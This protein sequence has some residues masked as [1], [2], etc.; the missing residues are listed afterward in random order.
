MAEQKKMNQEDF[1]K[2]LQTPRAPSSG[3]PALLGAGGA[4]PKQAPPK[5]PRDSGAFAKPDGP[6]KKKKPYK[7]P[8]DASAKPEGPKYRDRAA[9]RRTAKDEISTDQLLRQLNSAEGTELDSR[10]LYEQSKYLGGDTEHTHLVKGLDFALLSKVRSEMGRDDGDK[11]RGEEEAE[12]EL[13]VRLRDIE[14]GKK[15]SKA[16]EGNEERPD[17]GSAMAANVYEIVREMGKPIEKRWPKNNELFRT[18][19]MCFVFELADPV[20]GEVEDPFAIPTTVIRSKADV[21][22]WAAQEAGGGGEEGAMVIEKVLQVMGS[23]RRGE[24]GAVGEEG[25]K[26]KKGKEKEKEKTGEGDRKEKKELVVAMDEDEDIFADVGRDYKL[27]EVGE[28]ED[29][30]ADENIATSKDIVEPKQGK[31]DYFGGLPKHHSSDSDSDHAMDVDPHQTLDSILTQANVQPPTIADPTIDK[32]PRKLASLDPVNNDADYNTFGLG[33]SAFPT[34]FLDP[35]QRRAIHAYDPDAAETDAGTHS[36]IDQGT[37]RNKRAQLTRFNFETDEEWS[38]YKDTV[39]I[40]PRAAY[41]FGVKMGDGRK[42][43]RGEKREMSEKQ[44]IDRDWQKISNIMEKN[45]LDDCDGEEFRHCDPGVYTGDAEDA[46]AVE[47]GGQ[48]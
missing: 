23:L 26:K 46:E 43:K 11:V 16:E 19:R 35:V 42:T 29:D 24:R 32:A 6:M 13:D 8:T 18:G 31:V 14:D 7:P 25:K 3:A 40:N 27:D 5:T 1:R 36:L 4:R 12:E 45:C 30:E 22:T 37:N 9:E 39:E 2:L 41:Q 21:A 48:W 28:D 17:I 38:R 15:G 10:L 47:L 33:T 20:T 34:S 44:K